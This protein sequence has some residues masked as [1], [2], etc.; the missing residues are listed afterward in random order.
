MACGYYRDVVRLG[1]EKTRKANL[2]LNLAATIKDNTKSFYKYIGN[3]SRAKK[4][5]HP[6]LDAGGRI[7]SGDVEK[8]EEL[9]AYEDIQFPELE[10][11]DGELSEAPITQ[12][13]M[14]RDQLCQLDTHNS[15][16]PDGMHPRE[17]RKMVKELAKPPSIIYQQPWL[18]RKVPFV[19]PF[20]DTGRTAN[21]P[22]V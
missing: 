11:S 13:E 16:D 1:R 10:V 19:P 2:E 14:V 21:F 20:K 9:N 22:A 17:T 5:I 4:R 15:M 6:L 8:A 18:T 3:K 7:V 12:E